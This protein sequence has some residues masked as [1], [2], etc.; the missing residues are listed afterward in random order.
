MELDNSY[1]RLQIQDAQAFFPSGPMTEGDYLIVTSAVSSS[2]HPGEP[3][4][5]LHQVAG[6]RKNIPTRLGLNT[7]LTDWLPARADASINVS[8]NYTAVQAAPFKTLVDKMGEANLVAKVAL[9][10]P[11]WALALR[12]T[13]IMGNLLS[14]FLQ[15]AGKHELFPLTMDLNLANIQAGYHVVVG[16][17]TDEIWPTILQIDANRRLTDRLGNELTR[18][19]Y[20]VFEVQALPRRG[21]EAVRVTPWA[22][23]LQVAKE[24]ALDADTTDEAARLE[25]LN[26]WRA[27]LKQVRALVR[28]DPTY[29]GREIDAVIAGAQLEAEK[30]LLPSRTAQTAGLDEYP[31][32]W[33]DLLGVAGGAELRRTVR[34]YQDALELSTRLLAQYETTHH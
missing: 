21:P 5:G 13:E 24:Q 32:E 14:Y 11:D 9:A 3:A 23:L 15:E 26:E 2:F 1:C 12:I 19:C 8:L 7:N 6:F 33:Q 34:D 16:S 28:Q 20:V 22:Q 4:A 10:R 18:L 25:A 17:Y 27:A 30:R 31:P 29:L